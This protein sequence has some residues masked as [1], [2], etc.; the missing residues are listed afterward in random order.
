MSRT[1]NAGTTAAFTVAASGTTPFTYQWRRG[2]APLSDG[3]NI[4]GSGTAT[5]TITNVQ[6]ADATNYSV[7]ISN[8]AGTAHSSAA[9]LKV[10]DGPVITTQ[11]QSRTNLATTTATFTVLAGGTGPSYQWFKNGTNLLTDAGKLS[12]STSNVLTITNVLGADR[13]SYSVV[14][15][16]AAGVVTSSNAVLT[17]IDPAILVQP[18]GVTNVEGSTVSFQV[19]AVGTAVLKYQW[20]QDGADVLGATNSTL[21]LTN[22]ADSDAGEYTVIVTNSAG[23]ITSSPAI[24]V[25]IP[26]L[27]VSQPANAVGFI[28]Q[29]VSFSVG[30]NGQTPFAYQWQ[31]AGVDITGATNRIFTLDHLTAGDAGNYRVVVTNPSGSETSH[32]ANLIVTGVPILTLVSYS[33]GVAS[34]LVRAEP[35][36]SVVLQGSTNLMDWVSLVTNTVP[37]T[38]MVAGSAGLSHRFY[39]AFYLP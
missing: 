32:Y 29:S 22:I 34:V 24:L 12:G 5:L 8:P 16:N 9:T 15:S 30:V 6:D 36:T 26:P 18:V 20:Q 23:S 4:S 25:T 17:V 19:T 35:G 13:G 10:I 21:T 7:V 37:Y 33:N 2:A 39:R 1:N 3:G 38:L 28:G 27:I 14:I 11:P 31:K